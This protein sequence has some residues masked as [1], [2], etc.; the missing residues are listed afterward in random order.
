[1]TLDTIP[2][3]VPTPNHGPQRTQ[4][5]LCCWHSTAGGSALSSAQW[6]ARP[7]SGAGYHYLIERDGSVIASTPLS[8]VAYHAGVSAWPV[9]PAGVPAGVS[10]NRRSVGVAFANRNDGSEPVTPA[11]INAAVALAVLLAARYP[12][13][14]SPA[15]HIRHRDCA[16]GRK[17]DPLPEALNWPAFV[18][19]LTAAL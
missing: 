7:N 1:M 19:R 14:K 6:I 12:A 5:A 2:T 15:A 11:Q 8:A 18:A 13:L 4:T 3:P 16:P 10:I 17:S 9:P